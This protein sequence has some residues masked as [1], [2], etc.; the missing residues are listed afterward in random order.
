MT[1]RDEI[2]KIVR[3]H[4]PCDDGGYALMGAKEVD[5]MCEELL[6]RELP[7]KERIGELEKFIESAE[8]KATDERDTVIDGLVQNIT[9]LTSENATLKATIDEIVKGLK[10][11]KEIIEGTREVPLYQAVEAIDKAIERGERK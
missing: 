4:L 5:E 3:K 9:D 10:E 11:A 1:Q 7:L 2:E 8:D 6:A